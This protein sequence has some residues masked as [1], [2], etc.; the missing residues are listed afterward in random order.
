MTNRIDK[1]NGIKLKMKLVLINTCIMAVVLIIAIASAIYLSKKNV[2]DLSANINNQLTR[3]LNEKLKKAAE[4][5]SNI[6]DTKSKVILKEANMMGDN[7]DVISLVDYGLVKKRSVLM[8]SSFKQDPEKKKKFFLEYK[9]ARGSLNYIKLANNL[10]LSIYED[11]GAPQH[12]EIVDRTGKVRGKTADI[13]K[14]FIEPNNSEK[15]KQILKTRGGITF[16]DIIST[17][18]GMAMKAYGQVNKSS[19]ED[20]QPGILIVTLPIDVSFA[21]ELKKTTDAEVAIFNGDEFFTGTF[22]DPMENKIYNLGREEEV[23]KK[24]IEGEDLV[25][26]IKKNIPVG[27]KEDSEGNKLEE[28][29]YENFLFAYVPIKNYL[30]KI[31][32]MLSV[33]TTTKEL[34]KALVIAEENEKAVS[35]G[36]LKLLSLIAVV[37]LSFGM[38]F[39]YLYSNTITKSIKE[40]LAV[41]DKVS[42][43]DLTN[44]LVVKRK[45]E[46]GELGKGI[47][48]MLNNLKLMVYQITDMS[49]KIASSTSQISATSESTKSSMEGIVDTADEIKNKSA[50]E[51]RRIM[52]AVEFISQINAGIKE[53]AKHSENVANT[54]H[55]SS[56][57]ASH[58][59]DSVE[60]A[61]GSINKIKETVEGTSKIADVLQEKTDVIEKVITVITGIAEQTNLL[62][63]NAAI[64]AARAGEVGKG[65]AVVAN[66]VKKL[67]K[68]SAEA[69]EEIRKIIIGIKQEAK[70][71]TS[72]VD[73]AIKEVENG[74]AISKEAGE[75]L[76]NIIDSVYKTTEMV[77]EITASTQEQSAGSE[78]S[79]KIM[80]EIAVGAE[81]TNKISEKIANEAKDRLIGV[82]EIVE[83]VNTLIEGSEVL[84]SMTDVFEIGKDFDMSEEYAKDLKEIKEL[85]NR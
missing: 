9:A 79:M 51:M 80:E 61:I 73:K 78:E 74:V 29:E 25:L 82:Q 7:S 75:A 48:N 52:E 64:E 17:K 58:G 49:E 36:I 21:Y 32:G 4:I 24:L 19:T 20:Q 57:M 83:G 53:I 50:D 76:K 10:K 31:I 3:S 77:T 30:G 66:E 84:N 63:L 8:K 23:F 39:I 71:V 28:L 60:K 56:T 22:Y 45:D 69:A 54:S 13:P 12:I 18:N 6:L 33:A 37:G 26:K 65:F 35:D 5:S 55:E 1:Q 59:G 43:G 41:V 14:Q 81:Q 85:E 70:N 34:D 15:V 40:V 42:K 44:K 16:S 38:G 62:A 68:Q 72:S 67:A 11:R 46:I 2:S 27:K 47:N